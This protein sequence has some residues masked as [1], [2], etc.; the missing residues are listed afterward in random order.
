MVRKRGVAKKWKGTGEKGIWSYLTRDWFTCKSWIK[1]V[2]YSL[3]VYPN[4]S[5]VIDGSFTL[6]FVL[7]KVY[8]E[9]ERGNTETCKGKMLDV[10]LLSYPHIH[11]DKYAG[12]CKR[13]RSLGTCL[14]KI[15]K[16]KFRSRTSFFCYHGYVPYFTV[17][18]QHWRAV[19]SPT[20][21][22]GHTNVD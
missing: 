3:V 22:S 14:S 4:I 6:L 8:I 17:L 19:R 21:Q 15:R 5:Q 18:K 7:I 9:C 16:Q 10:F 1:W 12:C 11:Y 2:L 20:H 13:S